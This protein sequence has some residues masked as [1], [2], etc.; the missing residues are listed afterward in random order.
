MCLDTF[1]RNIKKTVDAKVKQEA[2][3]NDSTS[4]TRYRD[5]NGYLNELDERQIRLRKV[6]I[7]EGSAQSKVPQRNTP[8][9]E[10]EREKRASERGKFFPL[11]HFFS[12]RGLPTRAQPHNNKRQKPAKRVRR[13][14]RKRAFAASAEDEKNFPSFSASSLPLIFPPDRVKPGEGK[15]REGERAYI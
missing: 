4:S 9:D 12:P 11:T 3:Q 10:R 14:S 15:R 7:G 2:S 8:T 5:A 1:F 6:I 13:E